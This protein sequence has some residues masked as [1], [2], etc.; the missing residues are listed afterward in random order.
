MKDIAVKLSTL[1]GVPYGVGIG[2]RYKWAAVD[3]MY[4]T[5]TMQDKYILGSVNYTKTTLS[6]GYSY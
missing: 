3:I 5:A 2:W 6:F 1:V 4:S